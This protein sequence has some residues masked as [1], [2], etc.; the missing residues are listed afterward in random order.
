MVTVL[1]DA[2]QAL[3]AYAIDKAN[4]ETGPRAATVRAHLTA[5][6]SAAAELTKALKA[7]D[8]RTAELLK[9]EAGA[10]AADPSAE[11]DRRI[12]AL[13]VQLHDLNRWYKETTGAASADPF[14]EGHRRVQAL[15]GQLDDLNGWIG[16]ASV[17][18]RAA[19]D[20]RRLILDW[21]P[22]SDV[23]L[24]FGAARSL[25]LLAHVK[26]LLK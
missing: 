15:Q 13:H 3:V 1:A 25:P 5:I 22:S 19:I 10:P 9:K 14:V 24:P 20:V 8:P 2:K 23:L 21:T 17:N 6:G 18:V 26:T 12:R 4:L 16:S 7:I 11:W